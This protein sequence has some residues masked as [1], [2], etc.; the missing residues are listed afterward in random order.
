MGAKASSGGARADS[1]SFGEFTACT[2]EH[3]RDAM[4]GELDDDSGPNFAFE[5]GGHFIAIILCVCLLWL[6]AWLRAPSVGD[7]EFWREGFAEFHKVGDNGVLRGSMPGT[8]IL[9]LRLD[10]EY[11]VMENALPIWD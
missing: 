8:S 6:N 2:H 1:E 4:F 10:G 5:M 3:A 9:Q 7:E 11:Y